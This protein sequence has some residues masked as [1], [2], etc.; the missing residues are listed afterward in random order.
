MPHLTH[1]VHIPSRPWCPVSLFLGGGLLAWPWAVGGP[2]LHSPL[3]TAHMSW[4]CHFLLFT[5]TL[6]GSEQTGR[7]G[8]PT[9]LGFLGGLAGKDPPAMWE[10]WV[11]SLGWEDP[12]DKGK[13]THSSILAWRVPWTL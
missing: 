9:S 11:R 3:G 5:A 1:P 13:V 6:Q 2:S 7:N 10:T 12:L 4:A 8:P